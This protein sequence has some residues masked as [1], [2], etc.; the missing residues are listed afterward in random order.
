LTGAGSEGNSEKSGRGI[1]MPLSHLEG[2]AADAGLSVENVVEILEET[3][4]AE[5]LRLL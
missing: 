3:H 1:D 5:L 4:V 2:L